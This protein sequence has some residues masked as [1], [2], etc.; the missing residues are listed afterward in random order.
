MQ[1]VVLKRV[2]VRLT[3]RLLVLGFDTWYTNVVEVKRQM[4]VVEASLSRWK[5]FGV[6]D[7]FENWVQAVHRNRS[8]ATFVQSILVRMKLSQE[9]LQQQRRD[10][11]LPAVLSKWMHQRTQKAFTRWEYVKH[12]M[13]R[14][15]TIGTRFLARWRNLQ[16][17]T[18]F[19]HW[20]DNAHTLRGLRK[21]VSRWSC[22]QK[23]QVWDQWLT[24]AQEQKRLRAVGLKVLMNWTKRTVSRAFHAWSFGVFE[25]QQSGEF[26]NFFSVYH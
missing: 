8:R 24:N 11:L 15:R 25:E 2:V 18:A 6:S 1:R 26:A 5:A 10:A 13:Q 7:A 21:V 14:L 3:K 12:E 22:M 9:K 4:A 23:S 20:F 16:M 19:D 17:S